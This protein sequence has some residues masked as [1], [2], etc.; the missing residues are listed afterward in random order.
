MIP[1]TWYYVYTYL[2]R[3]PTFSFWFSVWWDIPTSAFFHSYQ[4]RM[5]NTCRCTINSTAVSLFVYSLVGGGTHDTYVPP[6]DAHVWRQ[7]HVS[8]VARCSDSYCIFFYTSKREESSLGEHA[9]WIKR[10][11][12]EDPSNTTN[13]RNTGPTL[14]FGWPSAYTGSTTNITKGVANRQH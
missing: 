14:A 10:T 2:V 12:H 1:G 7:L 3:I 4:I 13:S 9:M 6:V 11:V 8:A 5:Y